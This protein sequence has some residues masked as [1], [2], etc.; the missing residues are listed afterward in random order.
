VNGCPHRSQ[1]IS[2]NLPDLSTEQACV[3]KKLVEHSELL[4]R[5]H[6]DHRRVVV[7]D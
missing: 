3:L 7:A 2:S 4:V 5:L 1:T 6:V